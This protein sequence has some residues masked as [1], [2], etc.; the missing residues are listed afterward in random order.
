MD[1]HKEMVGITPDGLKEAHQADLDIQVQEGVNFKHAWPDPATGMVFCLSEAPSH[2][3]VVRIRERTATPRTSSRRFRSRPELAPRGRGQREAP[4]EPTRTCALLR[5]IPG[6]S[7]RGA[8]EPALPPPRPRRSSP[9]PATP[10][11]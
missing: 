11:R 10:A 8:S 2:E 7:T 4:C 5:A 9:W 6:T 1:V 3:A